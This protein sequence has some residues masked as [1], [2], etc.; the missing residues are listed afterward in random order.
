MIYDDW[1]FADM[2]RFYRNSLTP[3]MGNEYLLIAKESNCIVP[4]GYKR[5]NQE[6]TVKYILYQKVNP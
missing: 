6:P 5:V 1:L 2:Q 3:K 4:D